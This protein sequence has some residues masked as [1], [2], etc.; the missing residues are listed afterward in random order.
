MKDVMAHNNTIVEIKTEN[1]WLMTQII[2][3]GERLEE[4]QIYSRVHD[5]I[6]RNL[7]EGSYFERASA[8]N[9]WDAV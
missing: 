2:E 6:E 7:P 5:I 3:Q 9:R 4:L 8:T 1:Q